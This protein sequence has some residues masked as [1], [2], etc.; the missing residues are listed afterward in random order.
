MAL[1][2]VWPLVASACVPTGDTDDATT[3]T[4][5]T[6]DETA[7]LEIVDDASEI[8][9][10]GGEQPVALVRGA[11]PGEPIVLSSP[12]PIRL[13]SEQ[14]AAT[15]DDGGE[16]RL[17]WRCQ[18]SE[19]GRPWELR[20]RG[21][22]SGRAA[23]V[24]FTG[25]AGAD[26]DTLTVD[27][28]D[29]P[30]VCD[31]R[32]KT[33]GELLD[34]APGE[35]VTFS[36]DGADDL[37]DG[38]ADDDGR[39]L[40]TWD[41]SP[42]EAT[43]WRV[44]ARGHESGRVAEFTIVG[45]APPPAELLTPTARIDEDPFLCDGG[46][47]AFATLSGFLPGEAV[48]FSSPQATEMTTGRA[49]N[50]G[51]LPLQWTCGRD[52]ADKVWELTAT[53]VRSGRTITLTFTGA[54][55]PPAPDPLVTVEEDPFPCDGETRFVA[56]IT[57]FT[58]REFIDFT[59]AQ[60]DGLRQGQANETGTVRVR[61]TCGEADIGRQ[62]EITATGATSGRSVSFGITGGGGG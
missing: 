60:A 22:E 55:P 27:L 44:T 57:G 9:C 15:A 10:D 34:A 52:D 19:A 29:E 49:G 1:A 62:W 17:T 51:S 43:T 31:G 13:S 12:R 32:S 14:Q 4:P 30:F 45:V 40:L 61:W 48:E 24:S 59:S 41:C 23:T 36:A 50:D 11:E 42:T 58:P 21:G 35:A 6:G 16:Y 53:G 8:P 46:S 25:G 20:I 2:A 5:V 47:R 33:V 39:L 54:A 18:P 28:D 7:A 38:T 26:V 3:S 56:T 37:A